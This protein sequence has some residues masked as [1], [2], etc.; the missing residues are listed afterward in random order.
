M[1]DCLI[2]S[3]YQSRDT[4]TSDSCDVSC[5][6]DDEFIQERENTSVFKDTTNTVRVEEFN[7]YG[8]KSVETEYDKE[9]YDSMVVKKRKQNSDETMTNVKRKRSIKC[10]RCQLQ[11]KPCDYQYPCNRCLNARKNDMSCYYEY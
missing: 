11:K 5:C 9:N 8:D 7:E 10:V 1:T 4:V 3:F 6:K 2:G